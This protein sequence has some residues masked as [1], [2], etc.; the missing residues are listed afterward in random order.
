MIPVTLLE[1]TIEDAAGHTL[2]LGAN[3]GSSIRGALYEALAAMYDTGDPAE[4]RDDMET[5]PVAWLLRLE[6]REVSGGNDVPRPMAIRPPLETEGFQIV[7]GLAFYGRG[8]STIPMV[9]SAV[10]AMQ[11]I[12][13]GRGRRTFRLVSVSAIDPISRQHTPLLDSKGKSLAPVPEPPG[14]AAYE[15]FA[16]LLDNGTIQMQFLTPTRIL[17]DGHLCHSPQ[18]RTWFQRLLERLRVISEVY[19]EPVWI[20]F[21]DLLNI[22]EQIQLIH[23]GTHWREAWSYSRYE[24]RGK[25]T[26]GFVGDVIYSGELASL[27]PY[28]LIGQVIQVGKNTIKG[29][30]WY[31]IQYQWRR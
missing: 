5:N 4:S 10:T 15:R 22:A 25:P 19:S 24:G 12:G 17:Q 20:P 30:G 18:F 13:V 23:D 6:D 31:Q 1:F 2:D 26:S 11:S 14:K 28:L 29:C 21:R 16:A 9:L 8:I 7:F 27:L 3:P